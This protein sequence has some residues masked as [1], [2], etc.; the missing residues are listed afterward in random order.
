MTPNHPTGGVA[1]ITGGGGGIG[2][3]TAERLAANGVAIA[4]A[5]FNLHNAD[6]VRDGLL[7]AG[8]AAC[9]IALDVTDPG[10]VIAG[11]GR[12]ELA[13]PCT[14]DG[15]V[16]KTQAAGC[17]RLI[18]S[19]PDAGRLLGRAVRSTRKAITTRCYTTRCP[20]DGNIDVAPLTSDVRLF[21][22]RRRFFINADEPWMICSMLPQCCPS[23]AP[24]TTRAETNSEKS[25]NPLKRMV[26]A[27]GFEP[28][29][30]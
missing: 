25:A 3:A 17:P 21:I 9:S 24:E 26:P 4:I 29:T 10:S 14:V 22:G 5:D 30:P 16:N 7:A 11:G 18:R 15:S 2:G 6:D 27:R 13:T 20:R 8:G 1:L 23:A 28:L 12:E 19:Y